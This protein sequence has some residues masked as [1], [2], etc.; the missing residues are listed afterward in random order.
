MKRARRYLVHWRVRRR[1][2]LE[3]GDRAIARKGRD[4][5]GSGKSAAPVPCTT[6]PGAARA[7]ESAI[8]PTK[9]RDTF[10]ADLPAAQAAQIAATQ[11]PGSRGGVLRAVGPPAWKRLPSWTVLA[12]GDKAAG[13]DVVR[14]A[15]R[16][17]QRASATI[18]EVEGSH[19]IRISRPQVVADAILAALGEGRGSVEIGWS[20]RTFAQVRQGGSMAVT[21]TDRERLTTSFGPVK[22][23][24]GG[25]I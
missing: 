17:R 4:G 12:T 22:Q 8:D 1:L 7:V 19:V 14:R 25:G 3:W 24:D 20:A 10:A 16:R 21:D 6:R 13:T 15:L 23:M 5:H 9:L 2:E 18:I 11:L